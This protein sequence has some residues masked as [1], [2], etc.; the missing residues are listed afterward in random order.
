MS[1]PPPQALLFIAG[2]GPWAT[3]APAACADLMM[4]AAVFDQDVGVVFCGDGVYQL[5]CDQDGGA[6][7]QKTLAKLFPALELYNI[8]RVYVEASALQLR[9]FSA[10]ELL[11]RA[12]SI[13]PE[14]LRTLIDS[15]KAVFVF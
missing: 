9:G 6:L 14:E 13:G 2:K 5:L 8:T 10:A 1:T 12:Q 15:S 7:G 4:T 11:I 3:A